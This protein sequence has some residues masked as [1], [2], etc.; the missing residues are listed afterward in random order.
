LGEHGVRAQDVTLE[1]TESAIGHAPALP[2]LTYL[3]SLGL[4]LSID[5]FGTGHSSLARLDTIPLDELKIDRSFIRK[6]A[7]GGGSTLVAEMISLAHELG[8]S[9]VA[10]GVETQEITESLADL[11]VRLDPGLP[12]RPPPPRG[13]RAVLA[14]VSAGRHQNPLARQRCQRRLTNNLRR[15][16]PPDQACPPDCLAHGQ[17][18]THAAG[19]QADTSPCRS[20]R[21]SRRTISASSH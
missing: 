20:S 10:E 18:Q 8:L 16:H 19:D 17:T 15:R 14:A 5:D 4:K 3:K 13:R 9:V 12:P 2:A 11:G 6:L 21:Q 7:A 1:I